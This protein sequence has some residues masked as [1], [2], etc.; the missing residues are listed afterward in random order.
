LEFGDILN[1]AFMA[2]TIQD[3]IHIIVHVHFEYAE[4]YNDPVKVYGIADG[5]ADSVVLRKHAQV[6][7]KT[8]RYATLA[9]YDPKHTRSQHIRIVSAY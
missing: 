7:H 1:V 3:P 6:L 2:K 8:G 4:V 9:G 5:E